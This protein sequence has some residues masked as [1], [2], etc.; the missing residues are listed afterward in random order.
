MTR[1]NAIAMGLWVALLPEW[2]DV[3]T[4]DDLRLLIDASILDAGKP[5][6]EQS[7][8]NRTAGALQLIAKRLRSRT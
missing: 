1:E 3:D 2:R 8:S 6:Q 5:K 7:F 4:I